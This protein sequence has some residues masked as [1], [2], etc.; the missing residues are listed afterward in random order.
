MT[1]VVSVDFTKSPPSMTPFHFTGRTEEVLLA[2]GGVT[3]SGYASTSRMTA[4]LV[5]AGPPTVVQ[6]TC[7][8][9]NECSAPTV[10]AG[11][12]DYRGRITFD[13]S[14]REVAFDG[15]IDEFPAYE[16]YATINRRLLGDPLFT[17][18]PAPGK[19]ATNIV[20]GATVS[21]RRRIRDSDGDDVFDMQ[22]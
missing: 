13:P 9:R 5:S 10:V 6:L 12:I 14:A 19:T 20:G 11:D 21:V 18:P 15:M 22:F 16:A 2:T 8:G 4:S 7:A 1:S 17:I 3:C